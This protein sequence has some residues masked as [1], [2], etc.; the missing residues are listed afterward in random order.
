[1]FYNAVKFSLVLLCTLST[2]VVLAEKSSIFS[3]GDAA[4]AAGDYAIACDLYKANIGKKTLL[5]MLK[6]D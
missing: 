1:M 6:L 4:F 3:A 2:F 5:L